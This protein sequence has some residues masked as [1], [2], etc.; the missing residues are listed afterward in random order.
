MITPYLPYPLYSGGQIRTF[1]LLKKLSQKHQITLISFIRH[2]HEN[3]Y[4]PQLAPYTYQVHTIKR[5]PAWDIKNILLS[6]FTPYPFLVSIYFSP[7]LKKLISKLLKTH[8]YD[9][10]HAETFYVLPNIP[11]TSTPVLLVEQTIEYLVYQR[12]VQQLRLPILKPLLYL[13][14]AKIAYWEKRYW[15]N[16]DK[17]VTVSQEDQTF[18]KKTTGR[19]G[20]DIVP[21][22]VDFDQFKQVFTHNITRKKTKNVIFLGNF[23]WLPNKEAVHF[24]TTSVWPLIVKKLPSANLFIIGRNPT[25]QVL[26][27]NN[28]ALNIKV[29]GEVD[30]IKPIFQQTDLLLVPILN[31]RGTKYKVLESVA[32][33]IPVIGT[34]LAVEGLPLQHQTDVLIS[35]QANKLADYA[36]QLL[37]NPTKA[38]LLAQHAL[39]RLKNHL[40]WNK[41]ARKLD[42]IYLQ[43]QKKTS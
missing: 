8:Q 36:H 2:H 9:L 18:I 16:I 30:D 42:K 22:G 23:K 31:G 5:R 15:K 39:K 10:I 6:G 35:R 19:P 3:Q 32:A 38:N 37:T 14:V 43:M 34:P 7:H 25:Q 21:N 20:I 26:S 40:S 28:P 27:Y 41:V 17:L 24:L 12:F 11:K 4:I 33:G 13:D 29:I 1:N